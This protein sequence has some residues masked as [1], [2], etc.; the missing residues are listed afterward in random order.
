MRG[1]TFGVGELIRQALDDGHRSFVIGL[2]GSATNDAGVGMLS[3]LGARF[4]DV[5][6]Q[7]LPPT[8]QGCRHLA[9]IDLAELH[10]GLTGARFRVACDVTNPLCGPSGATAVYGPQK[11]VTPALYP[12]LDA[13]LG[14]F[15]HALERT[16]GVAVRELPGAGAAGGLGGAL[17]GALG[18]E[19]VKGIDLVLELT[20]FEQR[21][22]QADLVITGEG[23]TDAQTLH[24]K[25]VYGIARVA[26]AHRIPVIC[27]SGAIT[28]DASTL[29][30]HGI[31]ALFSIA[32]GPISLDDA[33]AQT[34]SRLASTAESVIRTFLAR[35]RD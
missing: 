10:P 23:K 16:V 12:V 7:E 2:G 34:A 1:N 32:P 25:A 29:Y 21:V 35:R 24:G 3:A 22:S 13:V 6:G 20:R 5:R 17:V 4:Y 30:D 26:E 15:A 18:G 27:I 8:P 19:L 33:M 9:R 31:T 14:Q 11:G 28:D